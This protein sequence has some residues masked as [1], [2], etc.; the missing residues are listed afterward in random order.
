MISRHNADKLKHVMMLAEKLQRLQLEEVE[1][2]SL[3]QLLF[4]HY[5]TSYVCLML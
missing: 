3:E 2:V 1:L 4:A 5:G